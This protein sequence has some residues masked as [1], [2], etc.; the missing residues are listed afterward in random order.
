MIRHRMAMANR[1]L[2]ES[3]EQLHLSN[4]QYADEVE[5][6]THINETFSAYRQH[7]VFKYAYGRN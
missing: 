2:K 5:V 6:P 3:I 7:F 4:I 1:I